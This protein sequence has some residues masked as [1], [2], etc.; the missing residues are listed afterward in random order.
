MLGTRLEE[1][2]SVT[3]ELIAELERTSAILS[4]QVFQP[5]TPLEQ[6]P[7]AQV[8]PVEV[9]EIRNYRR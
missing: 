4:N 6:G 9:E 2:S 7:I 8:L 3:G 1:G 5:S